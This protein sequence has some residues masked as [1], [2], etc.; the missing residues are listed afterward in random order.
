[1]NFTPGETKLESS[2]SVTSTKLSETSQNLFQNTVYTQKTEVKKGEMFATKRILLTIKES[3]NTS[4]STSHIL[5]I[6]PNIQKFLSA[7]RILFTNSY[8]S[9]E[10]PKILILFTSGQTTA[11][12]EL[13]KKR[14]SSVIK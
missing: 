5:N 4:K 8:C 7:S 11:Q 12:K 3:T 10:A 2:I 1:M 9:N 14:L 13:E 6:P